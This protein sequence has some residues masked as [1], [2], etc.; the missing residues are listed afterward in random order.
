M[1]PDHKYIKSIMGKNKQTNKNQNKQTKGIKLTQ[2]NALKSVSLSVS[3]GIT[4]QNFFNTY[5][6]KSTK[7]ILTYN[8]SII[9]ISSPKS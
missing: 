1:Q 5:N 7:S 8:G 2:T 9:C 4:K 3:T 6:V